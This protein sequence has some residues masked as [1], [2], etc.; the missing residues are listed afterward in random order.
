MSQALEPK[1]LKC[2]TL[3]LC[4][5]SAPKEVAS[6]TYLWD[7]LFWMYV[8]WFTNSSY[9]E[10]GIFL[11]L[12]RHVSISFNDLFFLSATPLCC[13]VYG[14]ECSIPIPS[15]S[16]Y[17]WKYLLMYSTPLFD[18]MDLIFFLKQFSTI[19]LKTLKVSKK[20]NF[21]FMKYIQQNLEQSSIKVRK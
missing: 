20:S 8:A 7:T 15:H 19:A 4:P 9:R 3:G 12:R 10:G 21:C 13:V 6:I 14:T 2:E 17:C 5:N 16:Q 18:L 1:T 11:S